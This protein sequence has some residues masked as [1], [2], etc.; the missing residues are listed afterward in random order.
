MLQ[1]NL[2][3]LTADTT[4]LHLVHKIL[5]KG[6]EAYPRGLRTLEILANTSMVDMRFPANTIRPR[7]GHRF[8]A[9]EAWWILTGRNDVGSISPYSSSISTFSNDG[10]R[11]DGAYGPQ[12]VDQIRYVVDSLYE[13][14]E[15]RQAVM[16][17]WRPNPRPSKDIPCTISVQ[18]LI[19]PVYVCG[20]RQYVLH[21]VDTMRSSDAFLGFPYD[22]FNFSCLSAYIALCLRRRS[23]KYGDG[24]LACLELGTLMLTAGSQHL[25]E[26]I[27]QYSLKDLAGLDGLPSKTYC[28]LNL[29]HFNEPGE[30]LSHLYLLK[31]GLAA[32][33]FA[34][35]LTF[36]E[37]P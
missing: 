18:W 11:F 29:S 21:C 1:E 15:S 25:Y 19:R 34:H 2:T 22:V 6:T 16:S 32:E 4:W 5:S 33:G 28:P 14:H 31:D 37:K 7:I 9:A 17:I 23:V 26:K 20:N 8:M 12:I 36:K 10:L 35:E 3:A 24:S 13:D 30:F 27:S